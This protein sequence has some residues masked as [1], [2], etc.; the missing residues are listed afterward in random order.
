[1]N[2]GKLKKVS[3]PVF[4]R[5]LSLVVS[6]WDFELHICDSI[7]H[8]VFLWLGHLI[9]VYLAY[10]QL[11]EETYILQFPFYILFYFAGAARTLYSYH[12]KLH[13]DLVG[14]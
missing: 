14:S 4:P 7:D 1:M 2:W 5:L 6:T 10:S 9:N 12:N 8:Q 3:K 11:K 13:K